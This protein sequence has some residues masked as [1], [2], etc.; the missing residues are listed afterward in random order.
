M[1]KKE[2]AKE[3]LDRF[4]N[5]DDGVLNF[6]KFIKSNLKSA[7]EALD[8]SD[9]FKR[10]VEGVEKEYIESLGLNIQEEDYMVQYLRILQEQKIIEEYQVGIEY[11]N[12][13]PDQLVELSKKSFEIFSD[14]ATGQIAY[15]DDKGKMIAL[16]FDF[17]DDIFHR[18]SIAA[19][20]P[21]VTFDII[22]NG[23]IEKA[24]EAEAAYKVVTINKIY[25]GLYSN[26]IMSTMR[27][28]DYEQL[29]PSE[30]SLSFTEI[31]RT[32]LEESSAVT[33]IIV[34]ACNIKLIDVKTK[35]ELKIYTNI[36]DQENQELNDLKLAILNLR[37]DYV[38]IIAAEPTKAKRA[39]KRE[40]LEEE[41]SEK[42]SDSKVGNIFRILNLNVEAIPNKP[43]IQIARIAKTLAFAIKSKIVSRKETIKDSLVL[44]LANKMQRRGYREYLAEMKIKL[45]KQYRECDDFELN[46]KI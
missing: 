42:I 37:N 16:N 21:N 18:K 12:I 34:A 26:E 11:E 45:L 23:D 7:K 32:M 4:S 43:R 29:E 3:L 22:Q 1:T 31:L 33:R 25:D 38:D 13:S 35:K 36:S 30:G 44:K 27:G 6:D 15:K 39:V 14:K 5:N 24:K 17:N 9:M 28:Y 8:S 10:A 19:V 2:S 20:L 41:I 40:E 46:L